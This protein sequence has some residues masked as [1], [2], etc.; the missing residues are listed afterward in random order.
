MLAIFGALAAVSVFDS[1]FSLGLLMFY[2]P[3][4]GPVNPQVRSAPGTDQNCRPRL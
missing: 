3:R 2:S 1:N 4:S